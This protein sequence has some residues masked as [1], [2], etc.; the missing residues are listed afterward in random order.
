[1]GSWVIIG[2]IKMWGAAGGCWRAVYLGVRGA[3]A[4]TAQRGGWPHAKGWLWQLWTHKHV[5]PPTPTG[6]GSW[7]HRMR[8]H[9][10]LG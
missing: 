4:G 9:W 1:M 7:F 2:V 5:H 3:M 10:E 6:W 8:G